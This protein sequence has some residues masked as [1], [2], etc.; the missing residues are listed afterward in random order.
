MPFLTPELPDLEG[1]QRFVE[2]WQRVEPQCRSDDITRSLQAPVRGPLWFLAR[3][4]QMSEFKA[5]DAGSPIK[6]SLMTTN[7][8]ITRY[9]C[10]GMQSPF[11]EIPEESPLET[12]VEQ[13]PVVF[14][15]DTVRWR[16]RIQAGQQFARELR[17]RFTPDSAEGILR[18]FRNPDAAGI[19]PSVLDDT[20][21]DSRSREFLLP[22]VGLT[23]V[24]DEC[25]ALDGSELLSM[26]DQRVSEILAGSDFTTHL[27]VLQAIKSVKSWAERLY[28]QPS[29]V[30]GVTWQPER[31]EYEFSVSA[32]EVADGERGQKVLVSREYDGSDLDWFDF[33]LHPSR[34]HTLGDPAPVNDYEDSLPESTQD[35]VESIP[36]ALTFYGCPNHRW[37]RFE[38]AKTDFGALTL[39]KV[40]LGK[41]LVMEF[42]MVHSNDWFV[43]P[44]E[45][46]IGALSRVD[47]L[48]VTNVFGETK[49]ILPAKA[50]GMGIGWNV[51]DIFSIS[52][53]SDKSAREINPCSSLHTD[54]F[55]F[56][57][58]SLGGKDESFPIEEVRFL[59]DEVANM[60]WGVEFTIRNKL[61][62][63]TSGYEEYLE[64]L[65]RARE[66]GFRTAV[67]ELKPMATELLNRTERLL[68]QEVSD[69]AVENNIVEITNMIDNNLGLDQIIEKAKELAEQ[70]NTAV[71]D[72]IQIIEKSALGKVWV[73]SY[74]AS[75]AAE[76][77]YWIITR[78]AVMSTAVEVIESMT[79]LPVPDSVEP[80]LLEKIMNAIA[81]AKKLAQKLRIKEFIDD[82]GPSLYYRLASI[83]PEN[84][85]PYIAVR[86]EGEDRSVRLMQASMIRNDPI[87]PIVRI[88]PKTLLL[89]STPNVN[90]EVVS[91]AGVK[92]NLNFQRARWIDGSTH[93]W[94]GRSVSPG[95]GEGYSGLRFDF[96]DDN[97]TGR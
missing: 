27:E 88:T 16:F 3:Q 65:A 7:T 45:M 67:A 10:P 56:I 85:I 50:V 38:D 58:P 51:W 44:Y 72:I 2:F 87:A 49:N 69:I 92:I 19:K 32:P 25:R 61:G 71:T 79:N 21:L 77:L 73:S 75:K 34:E 54:D 35:P 18:L 30:N 20:C 6:T 4:W 36:T 15:D 14:N 29:D 40:D 97:R 90:E 37:W 24:D 42:A 68:I 76:D 17:N 74:M 22:V 47:S 91:R 95:K 83:V 43:I 60:V 80:D 9:H 41:L 52:V 64:N 11:V 82:V 89:N 12:V 13:E 31:I 26:E 5:E 46:D 78:E 86:Q 53:E 62:E 39:D 63:P 70:G 81:E 28:S 1:Y 59:R 84:W 55:I 8:R 33:S 94:I 57:P 66:H 93:L 23:P 48:S 96:I